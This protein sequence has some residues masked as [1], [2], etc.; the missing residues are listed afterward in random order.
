MVDCSELAENLVQ[1]G[2]NLAT[3]ED[4]KTFDDMALAM[5]QIFPVL[6]RQ[7]I[8]DAFLEVQQSRTHQT[9]ELQ[10]KLTAIYNEPR[11]EKTTQDK[12]QELNKFLE[13][14]VTPKKKGGKPASI[15]IEQLRKTR[16]NLRKWIETGDPAMKEKF[17]KE[18]TE[19]TE[20]IE[21]G[22][23]EI[24]RRQGR[25]HDEV[26]K[27]KDEI[28]TLKKQITE[29]RTEKELLDKVEILE[30]HLEAGTLPETTQK[31]LS[32]AESTQM[33]RS[34]IYDLRKQL[35]RSEPARRKRLEKSIADLEQK[36]QS[37]DILPKPKPPVAESKELDKLIF[38]R[39]LIKKEI[40]DEIRN[41]KPLTFWGKVGAAWDIARLMMTT[42]EFSFTLRQGGI[43][44]FTHPFKWSKALIASFR[45]FASAKGLHDVN[46]AIFAR[47][48]APN[49]QK[50]KLALLHEGMSLTRSEEVIMNYWMDKLPVMRN[51][52]RAAIAFFNVMRAD[53]FDMG[54]QTLGR[55]QSMTQA[56]ME[57]WANYINVMS[58]RGR[59][60]IGAMNLEPAALALNRAFFSAR[61]VSSR[62]QILTGQPFLYKAGEGSLRIRGQ[63]AKEYIR[64]GLGLATIFGLGM[65]VGADIEEDPRSPDFGKL[66][67]GNRRLDVMMGHAQIIRLM[68]QLI[69]GKTK[70]GRGE[71]IAL[72]GERKKYG[73]ADIESILS[74]FLRSKLSPQ[75]GFAMNLI[76]GKTMLGE[77]VTFL[78]TVSQMTYP[79]TYGDIYD[80]MKEEGMPTNVSLTILTLLGM[81]LQTYDVNERRTAKKSNGLRGF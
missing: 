40:Q 12:I 24:D 19:L 46:K 77:E 43:Y 70:T 56:E 64:L 21:S 65:L 33:L 57:I 62:F 52:N 5:Q 63:I 68:A 45:S 32:G 9:A 81:G 54:Y 27:I 31:K 73:G 35:N 39:D 34:I 3:R 11:I 26:Q 76:T 25:L 60:S 69:T 13:E 7:S 42:G 49:Y 41:L 61:Y 30:A 67:F 51:F 20:K 36:I 28:D 53:M 58:G 18:V 66:K 17:S 29:M 1:I 14:G 48:N 6:T 75:F 2:M 80:V 44:A 50:A 74:R 10:K 8:V 59:L 71:I 38:K 47:E 78:N 4:I 72:R 37:G 23:I 79:I 16:D 15:K 22:Q 55:S